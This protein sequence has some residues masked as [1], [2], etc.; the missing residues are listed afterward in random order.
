MQAPCPARYPSGM[1]NRLVGSAVGLVAAVTLV[2][3]AYYAQA[4]LQKRSQQ[5]QI[6]E[7]VRDTTDK[8]R[9]AL[10]AKP[11]PE[12]LTALDANLAAARATRDPAFADAA[13]RY[14]LGAR[15]IVRRRGE[16]ERLE[17]QTVASREALAAHMA[18]AAHR[19]VSWMGDALTLKK[20]VESDYFDLNN[21]LKTLDELL[22]KL[23]DAQL[24]LQ[25]RVAPDSLVDPK[26]IDAARK[27]AQAEARRAN[28]E[29]A[30]IRR[31]GP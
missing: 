2:V 3:A 22:F 26:L 12:L 20:R 24:K 29:L 18:R 4:A 15:E 23:T 28:D 19:N 13:E 6:A 5:K 17:Q 14:I 27:E 1:G 10:K 7:S 9:Q 31:I 21:T 16:I 8:L 30:K 25:P 11:A